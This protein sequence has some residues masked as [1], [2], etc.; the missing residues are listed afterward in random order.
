MMII[1]KWR[2]LFLLFMVFLFLQCSRK[3][4]EI[5]KAMYMDEDTII[6]DGIIDDLWQHSS[7]IPIDKQTF[8]EF[9]IKDTLDLSAIHTIIFDKGNL[10]F[11]ILVRDDRIFASDNLYPYSRDGF[12]IFF[13]LSNDKRQE[14]KLGDDLQYC[15][16][17]DSSKPYLNANI[18]GHFLN[19]KGI[20]AAFRNT[21]MGYIAEV[22]IPFEVLKFYPQEN[23]LGYNITLFDNDSSPLK[24]KFIRERESVLSLTTDGI[25]SWQWTS[26]YSNLEFSATFRGDRQQDN[27]IAFDQYSRCTLSQ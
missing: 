8:G 17:Y 7:L 4:E 2:Y 19:K 5:H 6:I 10:Y 1:K 18:S 25:H 23:I 22:K 26:V 21:K 24:E 20:E 12:E 3:T 13:D 14:F 11:L 15:F 16:P 27:S 9:N